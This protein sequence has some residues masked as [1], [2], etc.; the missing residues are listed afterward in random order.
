M[1]MTVSKDFGNTTKKP[2]LQLV[3]EPMTVNKKEDL[4]QI[5]LLSDPTDVNLTKVKFA[6]KILDGGTET[7]RE[8]IQWFQNMERA[9]TGLNS[10]T[11]TL[12]RQMIQQL[13][14][15]SALRGFN[16]GVAQLAPPAISQAVATAQATVNAD[17]GTD[18]ARADRL[19]AHLAAMQALTDKTV[20]GVAGIGIAIIDAALQEL[21]T[22]LLPNKIL[23]RVKRYVRREAKKPADMGVKTYLMNIMRINL[24]Q[25]PRLPPNFSA[26]QSLSDVEIVDI[27]LFGMPKI[28]QREM[29]RQQFDPLANTSVDLVAFMECIEM[30]EDFDGDKKT[31]KVVASKGKKK[32]GFAKGNLDAD[33][34][35]YCMLHG[36]NNT[37]DTSECKTLM[38]QAKKL[39][40]N[41]ANQKGKGSNKFRRTKPRGRLTT[42][43]KSWPL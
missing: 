17:D 37:H 25:I 20:L 26:A 39:K 42:R 7:A 14:H 36:N 24:Q 30:S 22:I 3:P 19:A 31:T 15:G 41:N 29:D 38:A 34:S 32:S 28:W 8:I 18:V 5:Y 27:L 35:K 4:A 40:G 1:K 11:G 6:F 12:R 10:N 33:G 23:Q 2:V 9:F 13:A 21:A 16:S 43:R